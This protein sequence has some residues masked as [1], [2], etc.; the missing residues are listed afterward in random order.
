MRV[1]TLKKE[2]QMYQGE[3]GLSL[4]FINYPGLLMLQLQSNLNELQFLCPDNNLCQL[5]K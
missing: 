3:K 5:L 4:G 2:A 1:P